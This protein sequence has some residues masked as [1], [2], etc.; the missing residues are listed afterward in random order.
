MY[1]RRSGR[2]TED[3]EG[4]RGNLIITVLTN[5][6]LNITRNFS[7]LRVSTSL[8]VLAHAYIPAFRV[9]DRPSLWFHGQPDLCRKT[10]SLYIESAQNSA[11]AVA[12]EAVYGSTSNHF[13]SRTQLWGSIT[14]GIRW[15]QSNAK[16]GVQI[17]ENVEP[18]PLG[19][20]CAH[21]KTDSSSNMGH[22]T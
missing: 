2:D 15:S 14:A 8:L 20:L 9:K 21:R 11:K 18:D 1:Y 19:I 4:G 7:N 13:C 16:K 5:K 6:I 17:R 3:L 22:P 10:L 12:W